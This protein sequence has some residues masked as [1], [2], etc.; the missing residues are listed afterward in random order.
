LSRKW[1]SKSQHTLWTRPIYEHEFPDLLK[2]MEEDGLSLMVGEQGNGYVWFVADYQLPSKSVRDV[3]GLSAHQ[4][5]RLMAWAIE[6]NHE[7]VKWA[8]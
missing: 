4:L 6:H 5:R 2:R 1:R 3:W 8:S 7:V